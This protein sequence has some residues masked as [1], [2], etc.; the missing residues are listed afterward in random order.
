MKTLSEW[1][2]LNKPQFEIL[3]F[4][5]VEHDMLND[6]VRV[7]RIKDKKE[8]ELGNFY[9]DVLMILG[10]QCNVNTNI[11]WFHEDNTKV[12]ISCCVTPKSNKIIRMKFK[13]KS[14]EINSIE[15]FALDLRIQAITEYRIKYENT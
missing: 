12:N 13:I 8:F 6:A 7:S 14:C 4:G 15:K 11:D 9:K 3:E 2:E 5:L 1:L 10:E